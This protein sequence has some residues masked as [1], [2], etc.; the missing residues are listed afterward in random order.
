MVEAGITDDQLDA[1][2]NLS[3]PAASG[4]VQV[5]HVYVCSMGSSCSCVLLLLLLLPL[6][7]PRH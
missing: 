1:M 2:T 6:L 4:M 7:L 5:E 3:R